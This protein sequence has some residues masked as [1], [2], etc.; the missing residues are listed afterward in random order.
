MCFSVTVIAPWL[1]E[2]YRKDG[3][4]SAYTDKLYSNN[5]RNQGKDT[6]RNANRNQNNTKQHCLLADSLVML[7]LLFQRENTPLPRD[8]TTHNGVVFPHQSKKSLTDMATESSDLGKGSL[9][10]CFSQVNLGCAQLTIKTY[11]LDIFF[12]RTMT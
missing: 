3:D 8:S 11:S 5:D 7:S 9:D 10:V 12:Q 6:N 4:S 1:K 2:T